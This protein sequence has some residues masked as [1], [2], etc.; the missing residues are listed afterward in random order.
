MP[1]DSDTS[2]D[3]NHCQTIVSTVLIN[4]CH[5]LCRLSNIPVKFGDFERVTPS[6]SGYLH[7][8]KFPCYSLQVLQFSWAVYLFQG[9]HFASTIQTQNLPFQVTLACNLFELG[10]SLFQEFTSCHQVF[11]HSNQNAQSHLVIGGHL[12]HPW[13]HDPLP[14]FS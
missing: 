13:L 12:P 3:A 4:N 1:S 9:G 5:D 2:S 14:L 7:N 8:D 11:W 10:R 6:T